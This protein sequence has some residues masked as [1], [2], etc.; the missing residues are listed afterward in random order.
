MFALVLA[1][2]I[3]MLGLASDLEAALYFTYVV[4]I[5]LGAGWTLL[6][7]VFMERRQHTAADQAALLPTGDP[8][9]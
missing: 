1:P 7:L 4:L 3:L 6:W 2:I 5:L 9:A 8:S